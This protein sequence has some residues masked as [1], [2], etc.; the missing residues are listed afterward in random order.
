MQKEL[1]ASHTI[2]DGAQG[3]SPRAFPGQRCRSVLSRRIW[4]RS[5]G[6]RPSLAHQ[7]LLPPVQVHLTE[8]RLPLSPLERALRLNHVGL[9]G[10]LLHAHA[11]SVANGRKR[12]ACSSPVRSPLLSQEKSPQHR[13]LGALPQSTHSGC[14]QKPPRAA[15][16]AD[17]NPICICCTQRQL[18]GLSGSHLTPLCGSVT[19]PM[20]LVVCARPCS[21]SCQ[22]LRSGQDKVGGSPRPST[23][24]EATPAAS[25]V[26]YLPASS[27][28]QSPG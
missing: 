18:P 28:R 3:T 19:H 22:S 5:T 17:E 23:I 4:Q 25:A 9:M 24:L 26:D 6:K 12:N 8:E 16:Y 2:R 14:H 15:W 7:L 1:P 11:V 27:N 13:Y 20:A 21:L 10:R